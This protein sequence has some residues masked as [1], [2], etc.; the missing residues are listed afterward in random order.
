MEGLPCPKV[1]E[2]WKHFSLENKKSKETIKCMDS[3]E[4]NLKLQKTDKYLT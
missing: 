2:I 1:A 4:L 3:W